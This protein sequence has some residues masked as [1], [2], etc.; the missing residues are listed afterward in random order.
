MGK[1]ELQSVAHP[2]H[3]EREHK[4]EVWHIPTF[5]MVSTTC[6]QFKPAPSIHLEGLHWRCLLWKI[7]APPSPLLKNHFEARTL[8]PRQSDQFSWEPAGLTSVVKVKVCLE[9]SDL[10]RKIEFSL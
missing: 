9:T 2:P 10:S 1:A 4:K 7:Q 6:Q 8:C 5:A 3:W